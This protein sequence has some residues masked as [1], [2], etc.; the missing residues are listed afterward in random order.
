MN[1]ERERNHDKKRLHILLEGFQVYKVWF[2]FML[3]FMS[4]VVGETPIGEELFVLA[5]SPA[6]YSESA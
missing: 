3:K 2:Q 1:R 5:H 6:G 4:T